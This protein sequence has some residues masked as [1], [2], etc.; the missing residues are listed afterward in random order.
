MINLGRFARRNPRSE[1]TICKNVH[2]GMI[3][4]T[5]FALNGRKIKFERQFSPDFFLFCSDATIVS[6]IA[7]LPI[8]GDYL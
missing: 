8:S 3:D 2:I 5:K 1:R 6:T 7:N 4:D